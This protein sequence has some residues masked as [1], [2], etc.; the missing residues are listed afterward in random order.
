M[1]GGNAAAMQHA[2][3]RQRALEE[4]VSQWLGR[5]VE[6]EPVSG[7]AS[8]RRYFRF[9]DGGRSFIAM[10]APPPEDCTAFVKVARLFGEAGVHVPEILEQDLGRGFLLL[11]DLGSRTWLDVLDESNAAEY[12]PDA[13]DALIRIQQASRPGVLPEYD[14]A[15]LRRELELFPQ[16][17]LAHH[18]NMEPD[19]AMQSALD[20][21]FNLLVEHALGQNRVWVHRDY[22]PRNLMEI[23]PNPGVIDFQDAVLGPVSYDPVCLFRDAFVSWPEERVEAWLTEYWHRARAA[24]VPVPDEC[25]AFLRDCDLMGAQR[26]LKVIGIFAR[27]HYR[28]GKPGYLEDVPRF[29]SYL[30]G[31]IARHPELAPLGDVLR[32]IGE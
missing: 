30:R 16:W 2:D 24:G 17:Y 19:G 12:F 32:E 6:G 5:P 20:R 3:T 26:H 31:A 8:F 10:D 28:D 7:D 15:L 21:V 11:S 4:W 14:A 29:F 13:M 9:R 27:I 22:M 25:S 18:L 1:K 23:Q